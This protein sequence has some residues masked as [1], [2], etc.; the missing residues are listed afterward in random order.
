[1]VTLYTEQSKNV[2]KTWL[3]MTVFFLVVIG[4]GWFFSFYYNDPIILYFFVIFSVLMNIFSYWFSD[5]IVLKLAGAK[6]ANRQEHFALF[7]SVENLA[8]TAGLPMPKVYVVDDPAPNA[9]A[10][11]R[12]KD[13][14]VVCATTGLL[15]ILDKSELEG[16]IAHELSHIG[17]KDMLLSTVVVVLV[18][19]VSILADFFRRSLFFGRRRNN[20]EGGGAL[21]LIGVLLS[22]LAPFF[23]VLIQLAISRKREFLA[24]ASGALLT[25]YPEGLASALKKIGEHSV[26]MVRQSNAIAHLYIADPKGDNSSKITKKISSFFATHPPVEERIKALVGS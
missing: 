11:G 17:N 2:S 5:K 10:T 6:E 16:V 18:G 12:N 15:A 1:M 22:I 7:T 9:F 4:F 13:H 23:A 19:F 25:R 26:P 24:D 14:A 8:I 21:V 20:D 3:L